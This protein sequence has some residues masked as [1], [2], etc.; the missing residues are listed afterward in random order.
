MRIYC[1]ASTAE[2]SKQ[3]WKSVTCRQ[4]IKRY[5]C[6]PKTFS[7]DNYSFE[8]DELRNVSQG[9]DTQKSVSHK[10]KVTHK[11]EAHILSLCRRRVHILCCLMWVKDEINIPLQKLNWWQ[12][13]KNVKKKIIQSSSPTTMQTKQKQ[14]QISRNRGRWRIKF[15]ENLNKMQSTLNCIVRD[16]GTNFGRQCL[17]H[18]YVLVFVERK[19][20]KS[21]H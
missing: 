11:K 20:R 16:E 18:H 4:R 3:N 19:R 6:D 17:R 12:K 5:S 9:C 21:C 1:I 2:D 10:E 13:E 15:I 7:G 8:N 14:L